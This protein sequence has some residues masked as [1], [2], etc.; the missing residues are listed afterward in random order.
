M[1]VIA[2]VE[3]LTRKKDMVAMVMDRMM[4]GIVIMIANQGLK[5]ARTAYARSATR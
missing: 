1:T 4:T 5:N 2:T 3:I